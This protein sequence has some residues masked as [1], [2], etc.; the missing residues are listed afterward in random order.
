[1]VNTHTQQLCSLNADGRKEKGK[2]D[3]CIIQFVLSL[4]YWT[5]V[6]SESFHYYLLPKNP[7][8][9]LAIK[10]KMLFLILSSTKTETQGLPWWSS[11]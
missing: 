6:S 9:E 10:D 7:G 1:M 2:K 11:G 5:Q 4:L 3:M 8:L